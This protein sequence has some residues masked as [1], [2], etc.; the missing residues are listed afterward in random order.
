MPIRTSAD[1]L[2]GM[3]TE[4]SIDDCFAALHATGWSSGSGAIEARGTVVWHVYAH[5]GE[6]MI[7]GQ[8]RTEAEA[9]RAALKVAEATLQE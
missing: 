3:E 1:I 5:K 6:R 7:T 9:W 4:L 2:S 8:G